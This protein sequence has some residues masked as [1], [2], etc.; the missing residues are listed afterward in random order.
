MRTEIPSVNAVGS[1]AARH[2]DRR[3]IAFTAFTAFTPQPRRE[4]SRFTVQKHKV[5]WGAD[6]GTGGIWSRCA[7]LRHSGLVTFGSNCLTVRDMTRRLRAQHFLVAAGT[8]AAVGSLALTSTA[9]A[10]G[11]PVVVDTH[12]YHYDGAHSGFHPN[13]PAVGR[14]ARAWTARLDGAVQASPLV[15]NGTVIAA[16][17]HNTVYGL[18]RT[19]G[20]ALWSRNLGAPVD[21]SKLACG[22]INPLGITGTP[23]ADHT[24]VFVVATTPY[25]SRSIRHTLVGLDPRSGAVLSRT[26]VDP[27]NQDPTVENQRGA[28]SIAKGRVVVP[29]G[30]LSGDCGS[31]HG[32]VVSTSLTGT[33][34]RSYRLGVNP[35][36]GLWQPSGLSTDT[37]GNVYAVAGNGENPPRW[38]GSNGVL[39]YDPYSLGLLSSFAPANWQQ[40]NAQDADLGSAGAA[41]IGPY[42][43]VQGKG[44]T[45]YLLNQSRL[46]GIG[47]QRA[48]VQNVCANE[49][50]GAGV[51]GNALFVPCTDGLRRLDL[52]PNV[53]LR[54]NWRAPAGVTGSPAIGGNAVWALAPGSGML[55]ALDETT[56]RVLGTITVDS[57][58]RFATPELSGNLVLVPTTTGITAISGA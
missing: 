1:A 36:V 20:R 17:E 28:L 29:F 32:Y 6:N 21:G 19:T 11:A 7:A 42:V 18:S 37:T 50:G 14:L 41:L 25:G 47:G 56:G 38:D 40:R 12:Q 44:S 51:H 30:G 27:P 33:Q 46:G 53:M 22:N 15:V 57:T 2:A 48:V 16:T 26:P 39:K 9:A 45:G 52:Q 54:A 23:V 31:Y 24:H 4:C 35:G 13:T 43:F 10:A 55:Y 49:F 5:G 34:R 8:V 3:P 58:V